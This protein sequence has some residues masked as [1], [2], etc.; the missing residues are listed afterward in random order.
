M[1]DKPQAFE[2]H[3]LRLI[4]DAGCSTFDLIE[5]SEDIEQEELITQPHE[6]RSCSDQCTMC[7]MY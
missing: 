4:A 2:W 1:I 3:G 7:A 5:A 6:E